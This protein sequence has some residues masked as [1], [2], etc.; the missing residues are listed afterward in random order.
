MIRQGYNEELDQLKSDMTNS[1]GLIAAVE[2]REKERTGIPKLKIGYNR[3]FGYYI[4]ISNSYKNDAPDDYI[5]KQTLTNC[6]RFIT[7]ELKEL[8]NRILGASDKAVRLESELFDQVRKTVAAEL[9]RVQRTANA[10]A[11][12]DVLQ[13]FAAVSAAGDYVRP[14]VNLNGRLILRDSR[15]PVVEKLLR[16]A[17]FVPNDV[18]LDMGEN[19]IAIITGPNM[20]GKSTYMRQTAL[21]LLMAQIGC[22]VPASFAEVGIV[23]SIFTRVGASDDL[24][25]GQSTFMVEMTEVA[26]ILKNATEKSFIIFDEIGRGTST[27]DG[28]SIARAVLEYVADPKLFGRQDDVC[29]ALS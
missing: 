11:R 10:V 18:T 13:S 3:V 9:D 21:I 27:F 5:R 15:H 14:E 1:Q 8:E 6:E 24:S 17:P 19:R 28:M 26:D 16:G 12:L 4:E 29:D 23:D 7:P 22:F 2:A 25:A 20:A